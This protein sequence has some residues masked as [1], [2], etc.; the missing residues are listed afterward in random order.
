MKT[1]V[2]RFAVGVG[3]V[4][5]AAIACRQNDPGLEP[6]T[7]PNSPIPTKLDRPEDPPASPTKLPTLSP[8]GG[9]RQ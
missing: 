3:F 1:A 5:L 4:A 8:E 7:P 6:K 9:T 2:V